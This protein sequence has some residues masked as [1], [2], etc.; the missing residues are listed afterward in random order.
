M[1][2][3]LRQK[4]AIA[5]SSTTVTTTAL[6][7]NAISLV[8]KDLARLMTGAITSTAGLNSEIW[9]IP[10]CEMVNNVAA[11]W[12][13]YQSNYTTTST[14]V[15]NTTGENAIYLRTLSANNTY[16][17]TGLSWTSITNSSAYYRMLFPYNVTDY[18][19][20]PV[21]TFK[22]T[23]GVGSA[24]APCVF[25]TTG[26]LHE[27][28]LYVTPRCIFWSVS[29]TTATQPFMIQTF[30]EYPSTPLSTVYNHPNQ[31]IWGLFNTPAATTTGTGA[32]FSTAA[33]DIVGGYTSAGS[34][35][36]NTTANANLGMV[37]THYPN[38]PAGGMNSLWST[39]AGT[40]DTSTLK[41]TTYGSMS[42]TV[43]SSGNLVSVPA[44]PLL[45]FPGWDT[46]YDMSSLTG[47]YAT[48][49]GLGAT[50]DT[51]TVNGQPYAYI[52]ATTMGYLVPRQ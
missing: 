23:T 36:I 27:H 30:L 5:N 34:P 44:M 14:N 16:K 20:N 40:A 19:G 11:G 45:H 43:D 6:G 21:L 7:N 50:A 3:R 29:V 9:D 52:N 35:I 32:A 31:V 8:M 15:P 42:N 33:F 28:V 1:Y 51:L 26:R 39:A 49:P 17:Y 47:V 22:D 46:V 4:F 25:E 2:A 48:R 41:P 37:Y 38:A 24:A 10:N 18:I 13:E 12:S